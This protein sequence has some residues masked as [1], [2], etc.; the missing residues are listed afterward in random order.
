M[1][2]TRK[3]SGDHIMDHE[4]VPGILLT[5]RPLQRPVRSLRQLAAAIL[6]EFDIDS[7]PPASSD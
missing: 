4:A 3:W 5:N 1:D 2:N 7:F 6:A